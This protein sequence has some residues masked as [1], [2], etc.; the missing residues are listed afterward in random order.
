MKCSNCGKLIPEEALFCPF[1]GQK[2]E[3]VKK[4]KVCGYELKEDFAFCPK[5]GSKTNGTLTCRECGKELKEDE[6]FCSVCGTQVNKS[7]DTKKVN[8]SQKTSA[9][10][11]LSNFA[12]KFNS[13]KQLINRIAFLVIASIFL[14]CSLFSVISIDVT[15]TIDEISPGTFSGMDVEGKLSLEVTTIDLIYFSFFTIGL[16]DTKA[17]NYI[18]SREISRELED[19]VDI[20]KES[21]V[22]E[23]EDGRVVLTK[24]GCRRVS[25]FLYDFPYLNYT[26]AEAVAA[27][28]TQGMSSMTIYKISGFLCL[29]YILFSLIVFIV[30]LVGVIS[31]KERCCLGLTITLLFMLILITGMLCTT[32]T[33]Y[34]SMGSAFV[35]T[36]IF[37]VLYIAY[38]I[39]IKMLDEK[40]IDW[41]TL[42]V[43]GVTL[44]LGIIMLS[45]FSVS[46][47]NVELNHQYYNDAGYRDNVKFEYDFNQMDLFEQYYLDYDEK[48][49]PAIQDISTDFES[50]ASYFEEFKIYNEGDLYFKNNIG[51]NKLLLNTFMHRNYMWA[52]SICRLQPIVSMVAFVF[53]TMLLCSSLAGLC[54]L[55]V[56]KKLKYFCL[57][58]IL[59]CAVLNI[60]ATAILNGCLATTNFME[61]NLNIGEG[62]ITQIVFVFLGFI[63]LGF[64]K[65]LKGKT[66]DFGKSKNRNS[67]K[68]GEEIIRRIEVT[69]NNSSNEEKISQ[70]DESTCDISETPDI[71]AENNLQ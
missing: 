65:L 59:I 34:W 22:I 61:I 10:I 2:V 60:V 8:K 17:R 52:I 62:I 50:K 26:Y 49:R 66:L 63:G 29:A 13:K 5:C 28:E 71:V 25:A 57:V 55:K 16:D 21:G 35:A 41:H 67:D 12:K 69:E 1:C 44:V 19:F 56:S 30:A 47:I 53:S 68:Q 33:E 40:K 48:T 15:D 43:K 36:T 70:N 24:K 51:I 7:S 27:N 6:S 14:L 31:K 54:G 32:S 58:M 11:S 18:G 64:T 9:N 37:A 3:K 38:R 46:A 4:C 42:A 23:N 20:F 45:M 39:T